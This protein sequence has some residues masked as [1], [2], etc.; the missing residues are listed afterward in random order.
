MVM[1][2][3]L[4]V[5]MEYCTHLMGR[6][7]QLNRIV[8]QVCYFASFSISCSELFDFFVLTRAAVKGNVDVLKFLAEQGR[9]NPCHQLAMT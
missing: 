5:S 3:L 4:K 9:I 6:A 2:C 8:F 7:V 1:M